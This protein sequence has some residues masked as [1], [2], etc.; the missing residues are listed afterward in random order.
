MK[1]HHFTS[2]NLIKSKMVTKLSNN[3]FLI[4]FESS[5]DD[6]SFG[7]SFWDH[8]DRNEFNF[9]S[10]IKVVHATFIFYGGAVIVEKIDS[11]LVETFEIDNEGKTIVVSF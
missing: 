1:T 6:E 11:S 2:N 8:Y 7:V 3:Q 5:P 4:P 9:S 10:N